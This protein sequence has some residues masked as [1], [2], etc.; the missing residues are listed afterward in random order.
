MKINP[1]RLRSLRQQKGLSRPQLEKKSGIT[2][3]TIQRLENESQRCQKSQEHTVNSLAN[4]LG[5][6]PG[7]LTGELPLPK[8]NKVP[9]SAAKQVQISAQITSKA[10]LEYD[11]IKHRYGV[12]A[13]E[14]INMAPLFFTLLAEG[15][16][17]WRRERLKEPKEAIDRLTQV[18]VDDGWSVCC[19]S[20]ANI[21][22]KGVAAEEN[23]ISKVDLFGEHLLSELSDIDD[24]FLEAYGFLC[25][26]IYNPFASYLRKLEAELAIPSVVDVVDID[27]SEIE[28]SL[29]FPTYDICR[30][31]FDG[32]ANGSNYAKMALKTG[33][34]RISE[35]PKEL[36]AEDAGE[37]RVKWLKKR[38]PGVIKNINEEI[39]GILREFNVADDDYAFAMREIT[40]ATDNLDELKWL[41]SG[42]LRSIEV[43]NG[44][45]RKRREEL[46]EKLIILGRYRE[47]LIRNGVLDPE[48]DLRKHIE[49]VIKDTNEEIEGI[50]REFNVADDHAFVIKGAIQS[51]SF[52]RS[53]SQVKVSDSVY[54]EVPNSVSEERKE[55]L[56]EKLVI[57]GRYREVLIRNGILDPEGDL[58]KRME[59][60]DITNEE[61]DRLLADTPLEEE[62]YQEGATR[63]LFLHPYT[64][65]IEKGDDDQ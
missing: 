13:T 40:Q 30:D 19:I 58:R 3:R 18:E 55:E 44:P 56:T 2:E 39:E 35:I 29:K 10:R 31:E 45:S 36:M 28:P 38:M 41:A 11:L 32:I 9:T 61:L 54:T 21:A 1:D 51:A 46:T 15:S 26:P 62:A 53:D 65:D 60:H 14:L 37:E 27:D 20:G 16:L 25:L 48:G 8:F 49:G 59:E 22:Y 52:D 4:A 34:V 23:S 17:A 42:R 63:R 33:H 57:L 24:E 43:P 6:E 50:L 12:S 7:V 64:S 47:V 5:V